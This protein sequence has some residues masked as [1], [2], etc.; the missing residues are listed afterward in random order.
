MLTQFQIRLRDS[1][2]TLASLSIDLSILDQ[3]FQCIE[4]QSVQDLMLTSGD[5]ERIIL[6]NSGSSTQ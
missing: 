5:G 4:L 2:K 3:D 1:I 6:H